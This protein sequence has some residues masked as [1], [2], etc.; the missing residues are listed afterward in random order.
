[1][2]GH[3]FPSS[4]CRIIKAVEKVRKINTVIA[5]HNVRLFVKSTGYGCAPNPF[6]LFLAN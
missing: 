3:T 4:P 5:L 2:R 1:M 6:A